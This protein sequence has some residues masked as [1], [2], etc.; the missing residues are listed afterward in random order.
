MATDPPLCATREP[1]RDRIL[2]AGYGLLLRQGYHATGLKQILDE[3]QVPKGSFYHYFDSKEHLAAELIDH[4]Q[5][6]ELQRWQRDFL[7]TAGAR[8]AQMRLGL[9]TVIDGYRHCPDRQFGCLLATLS[10]ELALTTPFLRSAIDRANQA[11]CAAISDDMRQ[12][13]QQGDLRTDLSADA[14]AAL[15]WSAWQGATLQAKVA[16]STRPLELVAEL[17]LDHFYACR[18][19]AGAPG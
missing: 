6:R 9:Q 10:G 14:L 1:T 2:Q 4:Y 19:L 8:L 12:A 7:S 11:I 5:Q 16:R 15:F 3:A 13:Q 17:L 18:P